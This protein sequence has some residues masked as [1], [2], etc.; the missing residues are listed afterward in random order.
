VTSDERPAS[1]ADR[2][3]PQTTGED[4]GVPSASVP[5]QDVAGAVPATEATT[6]P[7]AETAAQAAAGIDTGPAEAPTDARDE[8]PDEATLADIAE[9]A[10]LRH[11]PKI[12]SFITAGVLVGAVVGWLLAVL[13]A[14]T[15][16][17]AKT[18]AILLTTAG[19]AALGAVVGAGL[20][21]LADRR[22]VRRRPG[23]PAAR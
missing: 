15:S 9:P 21:A 10:Q 16:G 13:G 6:E 14:G 23:S 11:A 12:G 8:V 20:A 7:A 18:G 19:L 5:V 2:P 3:A 22:S 4:L 17:E 1:R